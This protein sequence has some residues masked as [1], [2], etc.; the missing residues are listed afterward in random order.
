MLYRKHCKIVKRKT[1]IPPSLHPQRAHVRSTFSRQYRFI[2]NCLFENCNLK[3]YLF[4]LRLQQHRIVLHRV[5]TELGGGIPYLILLC[6]PPELA[7][8]MNSYR[9]LFS[10][11]NNNNIV[12][13]IRE[14][15]KCLA[16]TRAGQVLRS[17]SRYGSFMCIYVCVYLRMYVMYFYT[18]FVCIIYIIHIY[19][20]TYTIYILYT[21]AYV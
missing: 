13:R 12:D 21:Y 4:L 9:Y 6:I 18:I 19:T 16:E 2:Y 7:N 3:T 14:H 8:R 5:R 20:Y 17:Y 1:F 11:N 10:T 15:S